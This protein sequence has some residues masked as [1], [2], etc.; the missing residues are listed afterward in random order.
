[1]SETRIPLF[2]ILMC[3]YNS[4]STLQNAIESVR[5][6]VYDN[7]ELII[8]DNGSSDNTVELLHAYMEN[9]DRIRCFFRSDNVG[10]P[11]GISLCLEKTC[12]SYMMFLGADDY[13]AS[14]QVL[15]DVAAEIDK[16]IPD[17]V[18]TSSGYAVWEDDKYNVI[19][20]SIPEYKIY[21]KEDKLTQ[22]IE[23]MHAVYYNSVMHY[24][25]IEFLKQHGIDFY[26][27]FYGDC[28]GMTEAIAKAGKIVVMD[29]MS[30]VLTANTSQ[31]SSRVG[32]G[33]NTENQWNS[34]KRI[35]MESDYLEYEKIKSVARRILDNLVEIIQ[36]IVLGEAIRDDYMNP[37]ERSMP[38]RFKRF[39]EMISNDA[40]AEMMYYGGREEYTECLLGA[41]GVV[42][43]T[44]KKNLKMVQEMREKSCWV[45]EFVEL[46]MEVNEEGQVV[47]K[48]R[49][50]KKDGIAL[51]EH[52]TN[53]ANKNALGME[54]ILRNQNM[55]EDNCIKQEL[56]RLLDEKVSVYEKG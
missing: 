40:M 53:S 12:G 28:Q 55:Y 32:F 20:R 51:K 21:E 30:Y 8:L 14:N 13:L 15:S 41:A 31:T 54:L 2:S 49:I 3:T 35:L 29:K 25:K 36:R 9:D 23:I 1:M 50:S 56:C 10:W 6:Q 44:C 45:A 27:P 42:Y 46:A 4:A 33:Y 47:W 19:T 52:F 48:N 26:S 11:K 7:W 38:E 18:F 39:E 43:W 17:I 22:F 37:I 24:V 5:G 34:V 16:H